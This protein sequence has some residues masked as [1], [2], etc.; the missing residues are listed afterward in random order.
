MGKVQ[1]PQHDVGAQHPLGEGE[2]G[3]KTV[4]G[5]GEREAWGRGHLGAHAVHGQGVLKCAEAR[6]AAAFRQLRG[7]GGVGWGDKVWVVWGG[8]G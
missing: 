6:P 1:L 2:G 7:W 3:G 5:M 4:R 8:A